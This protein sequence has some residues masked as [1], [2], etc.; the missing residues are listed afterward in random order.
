MLSVLSTICVGVGLCL[1]LVTLKP[2]IWIARSSQNRAWF[3]LIVLIV[4]FIIGYTGFLYE[5]LVATV[6]VVDLVIS[7]VL[8]G[9]GLFVIMVVSLSRRSIEHEQLLA[10]REHL[11]ARRDSL[12]GLPNRT[13]FLEEL[14]SVLRAA[15]GKSRFAVLML[16]L[17][18]FKEINDTLGHAVGDNLLRALAERLQQLPGR[19][20]RVCR[21]GGDEF[22]VIAP[23]A[24]VTVAIEA[25]DH[26]AAFVET[27]F[28]VDGL[29]LHVDMSVGISRYPDDGADQ[30]ALLKRADIA[31]YLA[32]QKK[33]HYMV[34]DEDKDTLSPRRL[35][36]IGRVKEALANE[37]FE[38]HYQPVV[39]AA[40][41]SPRGFEALI[42]WPQLDGSYVSPG[43]FIPAIENSR[44]FNNITRW[45]IRD[46]VHQAREWA[47]LYPGL[48]VSV[49]LSALDLHDADLAVFIR[50]CA[51]DYGLAADRLT[52]EITE[53]AIMTDLERARR[54][55]NEINELG[56]RIAMDDFGTGFSS[57]SL[58][59]EFPTQVIKLDTSFVRQM[60]ESPDDRSIV[61]SMIDLG[62]NLGRVIVAEGVEDAATADILTEMGC[63]LL[64]G[65]WFARPM[66]RSAA[67]D[68]LAEHLSGAGSAQTQ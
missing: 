16:D 13:G 64:Q 2:A 38:V 58:L 12:T 56:A 22:A 14:D 47:R 59:R 33:Q 40:D 26:L 29:S 60:A 30:E 57:L 18:R 21:I 34:Y 17:D 11:R 32:K 68:W 24:D 27:P 39:A 53:S 28:F 19:F 7:L 52:F 1:L 35:G 50:R 42:R 15:T 36:L 54:T 55:I 8:G 41:R 4:F 48:S 65:Y 25:A 10:K 37:E 6:S 49:N 62:H 3:F 46:A 61:R 45:V 63:D 9:G 5:L 66:N 44:F 67:S 31:M 43:E 23:G 51:K 20:G